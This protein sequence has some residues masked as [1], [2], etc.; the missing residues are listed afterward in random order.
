MGLIIDGMDQK[1]T[2]F[3]HLTHTPNNLRVENFVQF[4]LVVCM[5]FNGQMFPR[6]YFMAPNIHNDKNLTITMI[7]HVLNH[8]SGD[9]P[10]VLYLQLDNTS[11][12]NKN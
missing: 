6:V 4:P 5:V 10:Q 2:I 12:E 8:W 7:Q 3:P 9:L 1:K 11:Q